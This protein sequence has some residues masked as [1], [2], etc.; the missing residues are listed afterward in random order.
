MTKVPLHLLL[1]ILAMSLPLCAQTSYSLPSPFYCDAASRYPVTSFYQ[2]SC[3]GIKLASSGNVVGSFFLFSSGAVQIALPNIP[4]P[5]DT[6]DSYVTKLDSFTDPHGSSPGTFQFDWQ[7][8]D[9]NGVFHTGRASGT[10]VDYVICGG[11][12]CAWHAPKLLTFTT[13]AN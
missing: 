8:E 4:Y 1:I 10:W 3:R 2:F 6:F 7:E 11:R 12:G 5:P 9:A 13:T